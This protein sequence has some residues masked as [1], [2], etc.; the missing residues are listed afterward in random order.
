V[1]GH[2]P[3]LC[4]QPVQIYLLREL[5]VRLNSK[6]LIQISGGRGAGP[7]SAGRQWHPHGLQRGQGEVMAVPISTSYHIMLFDLCASL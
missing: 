5:N 4:L 2:D 3:F 1:H 6:P 7:G